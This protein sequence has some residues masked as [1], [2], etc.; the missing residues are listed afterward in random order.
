MGKVELQI[1]SS[2]DPRA[3]G[4]LKSHY[5][6]GKKLYIQGTEPTGIDYSKVAFIGFDIP[7]DLVKPE[8]QL[9]LSKTGNINEAA[10]KLFAALRKTDTLDVDIVIAAKFPDSGL[11]LAINDRLKRAAG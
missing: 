1:N 4:Q 6:P 7:H 11:G 5:A 3:P 2:S 8:N 10:Q 9:L